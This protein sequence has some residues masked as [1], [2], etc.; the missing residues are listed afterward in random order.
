MLG[1]VDDNIGRLM[2]FLDTSGLAE[3]T[4]VVF[5][6]DHGEM[7]ASHGLY[8]KRVPYAE[9][10]DIPLMVRWPKRIKAGSKC[11]ALYTPMDHFPTLASLCGLSTPGIVNGMDLSGQVLHQTGPQRD[12]ALMMTFLSNGQYPETMT[13]TPEWR[14]VR[15][16]QHTYIRR[17][18]GAEELY[19]NRADPYQV[20][21]LFDGRGV[22]AVMTQLRSRMQDLLKESHDEF[23]P[24]TAYR[25]WFTLERD[26]VKTAAGPVHR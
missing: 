1:N 12:A 4:I 23:L 9:A 16:K 21:S 18:C 11:D 7:M 17:I 8:N 26:L 13:D 6:T 2:T 15:T 20:R 5:S 24:G 25:E 22:P 19:D 3:N 10:V 14:A